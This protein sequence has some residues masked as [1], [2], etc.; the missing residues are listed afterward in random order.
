MQIQLRSADP[1]LFAEAARFAALKAEGR[2]DSADAAAAKVLAWL[3]RADFGSNPI[4]D[5]RD[6]A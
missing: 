2:L 6:S 1:A 4:G 3:D 5:V